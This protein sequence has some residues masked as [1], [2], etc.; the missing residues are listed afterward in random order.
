MV[1]F[2][3]FLHEKKISIERMAADRVNIVFRWVLYVVLTL[4]LLF[5]IVSNY[6]QTASTFIYERF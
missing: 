1:F 5:V 2:V 6:G 3:D 4:L